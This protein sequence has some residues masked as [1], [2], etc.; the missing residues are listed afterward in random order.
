MDVQ[1][2]EAGS[3][4]LAL[5][6]AHDG[7]LGHR[8][9][10]ADARDLAVLD[11][12]VRGP[13]EIAAGVDDPPALQQN[14]PGGAHSLPPFA[15]SA[16][17][18][19]PPASRYN[20]AMR[21]A[22]PFVTWSRMTLCGPSATRDSISTPRFMGPGCMMTRGCC[23]RSSRSCVTPNTRKYSR[24]DGMKPFSMRSSCSRRMFN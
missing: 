19:R 3:D 18:A 5:H 21:T 11:Q 13:V 22:T 8:Q 9:P 10:A 4:D 23:A 14:R 17:S 1:V 24:S 16:S 6:V 7:A 20:T 12:H 2:H 15:A